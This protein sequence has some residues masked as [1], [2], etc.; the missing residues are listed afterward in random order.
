MGM[1]GSGFRDGSGV[2]MV[3][4]RGEAEFFLQRTELIGEGVVSVEW[5]P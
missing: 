4:R 3:L 2:G 1:G 5:S